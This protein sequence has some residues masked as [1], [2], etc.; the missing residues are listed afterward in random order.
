MTV[1]QI[2]ICNKLTGNHAY[3]LLNTTYTVPSGSKI[4]RYIAGSEEDDRNQRDKTI[5]RS[6]GVHSTS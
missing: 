5:S 3:L 4:K 6:M 2:V 1:R